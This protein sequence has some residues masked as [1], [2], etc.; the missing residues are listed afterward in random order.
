MLIQILEIDELHFSQDETPTTEAADTESAELGPWTYHGVSKERYYAV[1]N[2]L[3]K[4]NTVHECDPSVMI[5][6]ECPRNP[7]VDNIESQT[8]DYSSYEI[9]L[10]I[11]LPIEH[12]HKSIDDDSYTRYNY[13]LLTDGDLNAHEHIYSDNPDVLIPVHA[14]KYGKVASFLQSSNTNDESTT[15]NENNNPITPSDESSTALLD[16]LGFQFEVGKHYQIMDELNNTVVEFDDVKLA[17][18]HT[19]EN[20]DDVDTEH[21]VS[22]D[23]D[24]QARSKSNF[25]A[26]ILSEHYKKLN[27]WL[28][29]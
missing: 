25:D 22:Y 4:T 24:E 8:M 16:P 12:V 11:I 21:I 7:I 15:D 23:D 9:P 17:R 20:D 10:K 3:Q 2:I 13:I 27:Q 29:W 6:G 5:D 1:M 19:E 18:T 26:K 14:S 28:N